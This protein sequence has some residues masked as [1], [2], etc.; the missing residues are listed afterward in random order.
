MWWVSETTVLKNRLSAVARFE[1]KLSSVELHPDSLLLWNR[2]SRH[3]RSTE[4]VNPCRAGEPY[5][6]FATMT[7]EIVCKARVFIPWWHSVLTQTA[8]SDRMTG[9]H[10]CM[11]PTQMSSAIMIPAI[12]FISLAIAIFLLVIAI[13]IQP[14]NF[15]LWTEIMGFASYLDPAV[16]G[17]CSK[18]QS[19]C[20]LYQSVITL[21][22]S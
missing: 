10:L 2:L 12:L 19:T 4:S 15:S 9:L 16:S 21:C 6:I 5:T 22:S 8:S 18:V 1:L 11:A 14:L 7:E 20:S 13:F 3:A 17:I